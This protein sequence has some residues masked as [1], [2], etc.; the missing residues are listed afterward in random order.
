MDNFETNFEK[1]AKKL[2][3]LSEE[4]KI[5][6]IPKGHE[7]I[8]TPKN[9]VKLWSIKR[10]T[11]ELLKFLV[12]ATKSKTVLELGTSAG[13]STLWLA[14]GAKIN[15]GKVYT[16]EL[17]EPKI[18]LAQN[19]F[20]E[21]ALSDYIVQIHGDINEELNK[22][23]K[24]IDFVFM[25]ADK[26]NYLDYAKKILP[27]LKKGGIIAADNA[28]NYA[29]LIKDFL[30]FVKTNKDLESFILDLDDGLLLAVKK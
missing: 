9:E 28:I 2:E 14:Y 5:K 21:A 18:K 24:P 27:H 26:H 23:N 6:V 22:W 11:A 4:W 13:Y 1:V 20:K 17:F 12:V 29:H 10:R 3:K 30:S 25:D 7:N 8:W 19:H 16:I 15:G